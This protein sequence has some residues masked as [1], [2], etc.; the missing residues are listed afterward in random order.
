M[1]SVNTYYIDLPTL[2]SF[3]LEQKI[4]DDTSLLIQVFTA[5]NNKTYIEKLLT[6]L[7]DLLPKALI[8]GSTTD[9]EIMNGAVSVEK[10]VLSFTQFEH[11]TLKTAFATHQKDGFFSGQTLAKRLIMEDTK[12]LIAFADGHHTNGEAFLEGI[13]TV[14]SEVLVAGGLAGDNAKF[15]QT[16]VFTKE[17]IVTH[18]A[19]AVALS[20][21]QLNVHTDYSFNWQSIGKELTITKVEKNR[22]FT[23]D[24][25]SA[26]DTY[27]HYLGKEMAE[28]LPAIGIEF[29]LISTRNGIQVAR[30]VLAKHDDGSL[31]FAGNLHQGDKVQFGYGDPLEI[32]ECSDEVFD[33]LKEK[34]SEAIFIYSCMARRHFM[35]D[36]IEQETLP[37][38]HIAP[39][40]GFFTYGE[41]FTSKNKELLNQS[42]TVV[43][44]S[45]VDMVDEPNAVMLPKNKVTTTSINALIHLVNITSHE[46][47]E[48]EVLQQA[49]NTFE[50]LF[51]KSPDGILLIE[52][53]RFLQCNQKMIDIFGYSSEEAFLNARP[54]QIFTRKQ[55]DGEHSI[56]KINEMKE[57]V[58]IEGHHQF[59]FVFKKADGES[60]WT[61]LMLTSMVLNGRDIIYV[62][63]RDISSRKEMELELSRQKSVLYYQANHD[64]LTGLP[65]R[66]HFKNELKKELQK[67]AKLK[68]KLALMFIDLDRFKKIND[69]LGHDIGDKVIHIIGERL[70]RS[71]RKE[72][73]VARLGGDEFLLMLKNVKRDEDILMEAQRMLKIIEEP[74]AVEDYTLYSSASIGISSYPEDGIHE[75]NLLKYADT[76]MYKAKEEGGNNVQFYR[77]E[78][79]NTAY[80]HVMME[81]DLREGI[82]A[83]DLEVYY[84]PQIDVQNDMIIGV[85]ALVRWH[86]P[87][88]GLLSPDIFIPLAEKTGLIVALDLWVMKTAMR[89]VAQWHTEGLNPGNLA[90]NMSMKQLES[91][92][93]EEEVH[94]NLSLFSFKKQ[95]LTFEITET[96]V[97]KKPDE[98]IAILE[99]LHNLGISI[100]IDDF[101]TGYSSL[102]HLKRLP[103]DK[104]KIDKTFINDIPGDEDALAIVKTIIALA[105]TLNLDV[106]AEGVEDEVQKEFLIEEGCDVLQGYYYSRPLPANEMKEMLLAQKK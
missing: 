103:I 87:I 104:L 33:K 62:V 53:D 90:L 101:G 24:N 97:M 4:V 76:A 95:W 11:T 61:D 72:D 69:S 94:N 49:Q 35:P 82:L 78:M 9:G 37:L 55:P 12:L 32:L 71:I 96:E 59:E 75:N 105:E 84:Q 58:H 39:S 46:A 42:M 18:G 34:P 38:H 8:I 41:F 5:Q 57:M 7:T 93:F 56:V 51:E 1:K 31:S 14:N 2:R 68:T 67:T 66:I 29:P 17:G 6:D 15:I 79:T 27:S 83:D 10:T 19:V 92:S 80:E 81:R 47:M 44:L 45:E 30:A 73:M 54:D 91:L 65:N 48:K 43:S 63:C 22:V 16:Y 100:A 60:I 106:I 74:I 20:S 88:V 99:T 40:S 98:V 85:E 70:K 25:R 23:I 77:S 50:T 13:D 21:K 86:H 52:N 89:Q 102:S 28:G 3:V 36:L 26:V 64:T